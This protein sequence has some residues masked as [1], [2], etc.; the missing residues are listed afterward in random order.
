[1][2]ST[3]LTFNTHLS[4]EHDHI[5]HFTSQHALNLSLRPDYCGAATVQALIIQRRAV[6]VDIIPD[7][8]MYNC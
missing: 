7:P 1:M 5:L 4:L 3:P 8:K 2:R 6:G